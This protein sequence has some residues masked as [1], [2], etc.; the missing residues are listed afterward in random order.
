[1]ALG[2]KESKGLASS[3]PASTTPAGLSV[4]HSRWFPSRIELLGSQ[5]LFPGEVF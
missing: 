2:S 5:K 4:E 1:M 3:K